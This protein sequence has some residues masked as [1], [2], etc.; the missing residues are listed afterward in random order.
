MKT[1]KDFQFE[2][3]TAFVRVDLNCPVDEKTKKVEPSERIAG[4]AKTVAALSDK[5]A[6]VVV[7]A[8]QGRKGDYDCISLSQHALLL[9]DA[10]KK[11]VKFVDDV[12]GEKAKAAI[13]SLKPGEILLLENVRFLDDETKYKTIEENEKAT[14]VQQ[15]SP[16]CDVFVLDAFSAAHRAQAS[17]VGFYKK[18]VVAGLVMQAELEA[19]AKLKNPK[20]PVAFVFGG[21]KPEDSI[22]IM[23]NWLSEGKIDHALTCGLLGEL[24]LVA[25]GRELGKTIE[26]LKEKKA[27]DYLPQAR[28]LLSKH[29]SRILIPEDVAIDFNGK[30]KEIPCHQLPS[31]HL[32]CDIGAKTAKK[33]AEVLS[34]AKTVLMNGP[35]GMYENPEFE[36][37]TRSLLKAIEK[38]GAF[39]VMG[40]GHTISA[41]EK[42]R[43]NKKKLGYV[44]LAGKALIEYLSGAQLPG[45]KILQ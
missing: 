28:E 25:S 32:I 17:I 43:I 10:T 1:L 31:N 18:P 37:G 2:G 24:F 4:H 41:I 39:S 12:C 29:K 40:G 44:S 9:G 20:K 33:Y 3:K 23:S 34:G 19:L 14:I 8:H 26:L 6:R 21:A 45:V 35:A 15:L 7:L 13:R 38:S 5:G 11:P 30:R 27:L 16:L 22:G 42:F 36:A